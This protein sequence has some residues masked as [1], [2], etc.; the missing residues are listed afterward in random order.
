MV[1]RSKFFIT[2]LLLTC[3]LL[4]PCCFTSF[5][6]GSDAIKPGDK[7]GVQFTCRFPNGDIAA[8]TSS[9]VAADSSLR[10][11]PV[12]LPRSKDDPLAVT[13]GQNFSTEQFPARFMETIVSRISNSLPGTRLG[14]TRTIEIRSERASDVPEKE[15]FLELSRIRQMPKEI[16]MTADE[17]KTHT[18]KDP[19]VGT[20]F[21]LADNDPGKVVSVSESGVLIRSL[22]EPGSQIDTPFGKGT[23]RENGNQFDVV[24]DAAKGSLVRMGPVVGRISDVQEK[25]FTVDFG[26]PLGGEPLACEVKTVEISKD[27]LSRGEK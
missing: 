23:V 11:S 27:K 4:I 5:A 25:I 19:A 14:E 7:V 9:A 10:K 3:T 22:F 17:Y 12:Y 1:N 8:S 13:A 18:G 26:N 20:E 16:R 6:A 15:Q 21:P 24:I 2:S